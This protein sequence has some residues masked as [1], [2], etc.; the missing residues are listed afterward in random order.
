[1]TEYEILSVLGQHTDTMISLL[2][3]WAG[4]TLG[5]L[6]GVHVI[7]KDLNGYIASL[8]IGLYVAFTATIS[9]LESTHLG[10]M[11]LLNNDLGQLQAQGVS[12][13]EMAQTLTSVG[14]PPAVVEISAAI[15]FWG[16]F[17]STIA[18]VIYCYR[19]AKRGD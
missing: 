8:L 3:W 2:Q 19:K 13:S 10:R 16:L 4:I 12:L 11:R 15:G 6:V 5:I 7:G 1:M 9:A 18:Y 14:G 17:L